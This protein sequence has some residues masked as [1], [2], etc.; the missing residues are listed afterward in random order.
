MPTHVSHSQISRVVSHTL[1]CRFFSHIR[2]SECLPNAHPLDSRM[3]IGFSL[4]LAHRCRRRRRFGCNRYNVGEAAVEGVEDWSRCRGW[5][6]PRRRNTLCTV[7]L[8]AGLPPPRTPTW[9]AQRYGSA[10]LFTSCLDSGAPPF[11]LPTSHT[12]DS[13]AVLLY[14][15][16]YGM[17][18][19]ASSRSGFA[20]DVGSGMKQGAS[21]PSA[22]RRRASKERH[23]VSRVWNVDS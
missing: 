13:L 5:K 14:R 4:S 16:C 11:P 15:S 23:P 8:I 20:F 9:C 12:S 17:M 2:L 7:A 10:M 1:H 3:S 21:C 22:E 19:F 6:L 18:G